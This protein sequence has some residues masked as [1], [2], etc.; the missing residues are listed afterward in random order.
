L[1]TA[2]CTGVSET[3]QPGAW[4][5]RAVRND[6]TRLKQTSPAA[7]AAW[8]GQNASGGSGWSCFWFDSVACRGNACV[9]R[10]GRGRGRGNADTRTCTRIRKR[11]QF[12]YRR[13]ECDAGP[14]DAQRNLA[15]P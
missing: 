2:F 3:A 8:R 10:C 15:K 7:N 4:A 9:A 14:D 5:A 13:N 1:P 12:L 11:P 6:F